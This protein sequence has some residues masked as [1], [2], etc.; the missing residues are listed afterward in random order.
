MTT[1]DVSALIPTNSPL[2]IVRKMGT[3]DDEQKEKLITLDQYLTGEQPLSWIA[4]EIAKSTEGRLRSLVI[5]WP[6][7]VISAVEERLDIEGFRSPGSDKPDAALWDIWQRNN[8]D[9]M[10]QLAHFDSLAYGRSYV[11]VWGGTNGRACHN[12]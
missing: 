7:L 10:S 2:D 8:L 1:T 12:S 9:E 6:R 4:P 11:L 5:G 3:R